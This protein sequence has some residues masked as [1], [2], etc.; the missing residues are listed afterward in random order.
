MIHCSEASVLITALV[1]GELNLEEM[2]RIKTHLAMCE[3]CQER[4]HQESR[5]K[6]FLK[7][8]LSRVDT[9]V[10]LERRIRDCLS[11]TGGAPS[12]GDSAGDA[13]TDESHPKADNAVDQR[14]SGYRMPL[15][16]LIVILASMLGS[17][18]VM[19]GGGNQQQPAGSRLA[20]EL[21]ALH[22]AATNA[23]VLQLR[24]RNPK[25]LEAWLEQRVGTD[26]TVPDLGGGLAPVGARVVTI[27]EVPMGMLLYRVELPAT[28][29]PPVTVIQSSQP[30]PVGM[31]RTDP[32]TVDG[33][34]LYPD[35]FQGIG[36]TYFEHDDITWM[37]ASE[38]TPEQMADLARRVMTP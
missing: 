18:L 32:V 26:L 21:V 7:T 33:T 14:A 31:F 35:T 30:S 25:A 34:T 20:V 1:D 13:D 28:E 37:M 15:I 9:P 2:A 10:S 4:R 38:R 36:M 11:E 27:E 29:P 19:K 5:L 22:M 23:G 3:D 6:T 16:I 12:V 17:M 24:E 8:R